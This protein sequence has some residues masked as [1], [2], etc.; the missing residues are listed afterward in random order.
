LGVDFL[1]RSSRR[2]SR[3]TVPVLRRTF[4]LRRLEPYGIDAD[5]ATTRE[6]A[7]SLL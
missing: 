1:R 6:L 5:D 7:D 2:K 4:K 3:K